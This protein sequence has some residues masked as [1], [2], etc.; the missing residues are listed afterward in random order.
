VQM[1][2]TMGVL[3]VVSNTYEVPNM[4]RANT[5]IDYMIFAVRVV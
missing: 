2:I 5:G 3:E 4:V 1:T